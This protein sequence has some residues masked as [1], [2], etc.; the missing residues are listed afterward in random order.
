MNRTHIIQSIIDAKKAINYLEIGVQNG[1]NFFRIHAQHKVAVDP[2]FTFFN[3]R[4]FGLSLK[5]NRSK[6]SKY[7][8]CSSDDYFSQHRF[9]PLFDVIFI[10]GLHT[11]EQSLKDVL[12]AL[13]RLSD[14]GVVI[15]HDCNPPTAMEAY[16]A[17][18]WQHVAR[19]RLPGW[20]GVWCGEVWKTIV[21]LRVLRSDLRIFVLDCDLG[22]GIITKGVPESVSRLKLQDISAMTFTDLAGNRTDLINLKRVDYLARYLAE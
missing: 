14:T 22:I 4:T 3:L 5:Y 18:S 7:Y 11:F 6:S 13:N 20:S 17:K 12:N 1:A 19:L 15:L 21:Y 16:P 10:D 9:P 2:S 8:R